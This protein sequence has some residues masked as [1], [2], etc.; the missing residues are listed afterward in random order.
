MPYEPTNLIVYIFN[1]SFHVTIW[2]ENRKSNSDI[3]NRE[4]DSGKCKLAVLSAYKMLEQIGKESSLE[5]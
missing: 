4:H 1:K 3:F 2:L 5:M